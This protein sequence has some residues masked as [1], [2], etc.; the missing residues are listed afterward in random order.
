MNVCTLQFYHSYRTVGAVNWFRR[1]A[2]IAK[3]HIRITSDK[4][5]RS[6][7]KVTALIEGHL[8]R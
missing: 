6:N 3:I 2:V 7:K 1:D 8:G 4:H 5:E